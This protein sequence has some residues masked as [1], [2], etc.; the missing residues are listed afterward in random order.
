VT[1]WPAL[2][3][4]LP[5]A[6]LGGVLGLDVVS[7]PQAMLSRPI[8][9]ATLAG[10][11]VGDPLRGLLLGAT[12][13]LFALETLPFGASRYPEW[14]SASVVGGALLAGPV[15]P[16]PGAFAVALLAS[17]AVAWIGGQSMVWLRR[18]N[19]HWARERLVALDHGS[20]RTVV[21]LQLRGMTAD[22]LRGVVLT[23]VMLLVLRPASAFLLGHWSGSDAG[24]RA[25][26]VGLAAMVAAAAAWK[27]FHAMRHAR[28]LFGVGLAVGALL[29]AVRA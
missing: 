21:G 4:L 8:V 24:A 10:A 19:A 22:L 18:L 20:G 28:L 9:A 25:V 11:L 29:L 17:L 14:G 12:L 16:A 26:A 13:E 23:T 7:F 5:V 6:L 27:L 3:D 1:S 2:L 15:N